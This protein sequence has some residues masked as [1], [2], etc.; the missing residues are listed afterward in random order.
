MTD[1]CLNTYIH[2]CQGH[3]REVPFWAKVVGKRWD[4]VEPWKEAFNRGF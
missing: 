1:S 4:L 2:A 3:G